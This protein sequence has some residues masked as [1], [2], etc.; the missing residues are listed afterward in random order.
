MIERWD[1]WICSGQTQQ[2]ANDFQALEI[3]L[4]KVPEDLRITMAE[5]LRRA[6]LTNDA[7]RLL[8]PRVRGEIPFKKSS[9]L[10]VIEYCNG[11]RKMGLG[12]EAFIRLINIDPEKT[13]EVL[14]DKGG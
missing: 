14:W 12:N 10:E 9:D 4:S 1:Q 11:L 3:D 5:V 8:G 6:D 2:V 7:V 13:P